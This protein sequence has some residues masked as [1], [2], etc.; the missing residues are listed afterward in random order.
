[1]KYKHTNFIARHLHKLGLA[2]SYLYP[3][4]GKLDQLLHLHVL[5]QNGLTPSPST[6]LCA[7]RIVPMQTSLLGECPSCCDHS[8]ACQQSKVTCLKS[9]CRLTQ[10][11]PASTIAAMR[12]PT[13]S[14]DL[15]SS[16][17][18]PH[19]SI[20]YSTLSNVTFSNC[21]G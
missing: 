14:E 7:L 10:P 16:E 18:M 11:S 15:H 21:H 20:K 1:M 4:L 12:Q 8:A 13:I 9:T 5:E 2:N 3:A 17:V 19:R 6:G